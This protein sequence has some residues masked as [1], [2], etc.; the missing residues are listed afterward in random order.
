MIEC[1]SHGHYSI[2]L[3]THAQ[4]VT[5]GRA[6]ARLTSVCSAELH[7]GLRNP[8]LLEQN[9]PLRETCLATSRGVASGSHLH[10]S[11]SIDDDSVRVSPG[12]PLAYRPSC[13]SSKLRLVSVRVAVHELQVSPRG[14]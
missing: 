6:L 8:W 4:R 10:Q 5:D 3:I 11:L 7:G 13:N 1:V 2:S 9:N 14:C 12:G